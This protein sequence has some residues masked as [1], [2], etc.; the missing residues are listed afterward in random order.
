M[1]PSPGQQSDPFTLCPAC[2]LLPRR[3]PIWVLLLTAVS[4]AGCVHYQPKPIALEQTADAFDGRQ[5]ASSDLRMFLATGAGRDFDEWPLR[6]WDFETLTLAAFYYHPLLDLARAQWG[7]TAAAIQTAKDGS[8][9]PPASG[10]AMTSTLR[11]RFL[12]G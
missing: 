11:T 2:L 4:I 12:R 6:S 7:V 1:K 5:L 3:R 9:P 8:I 10:R